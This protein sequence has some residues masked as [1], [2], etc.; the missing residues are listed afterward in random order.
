MSRNDDQSTSQINVG[1]DINFFG[2]TYSSVYINN[3]G[4]ITFDEPLG[5]FT[6]FNLLTT[7]TKIIAPFFA[8]VDTRNPLSDVT[9]WGPGA[10][11]GHD[12]FGVTWGDNVGVGYFNE[13]VDKLNKFQLVLVAR[14]DVS[15]GDFDIIFNYDQ[16]QWETGD[17]SGG[18]SGLGGSSA[19]AGY[20]N[21]TD[22]F[23]E[24]PGSA[25][26]GA[27]LD[28]GPYALVDHSNIGVPGRYRFEVRS[29]QVLPPP[30]PGPINGVP[31]A[32]STLA[33][34]SLALLGLIAFARKKA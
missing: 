3:N 21:G 11:D 30:P 16:I 28:G 22:H 17:V 14:A 18:R 13:R 23:Y 27:F 10:F 31:D 24:L 34:L 29:G 1:F 2:H 20:S 8:D 6:P 33:M 25:I 9:K 19:R 7:S 12:A 5:T 15:A 32:G 4:N 26:N